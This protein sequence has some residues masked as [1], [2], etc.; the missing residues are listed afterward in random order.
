MFFSRLVIYS[1]NQC[2]WNKKHVFYS[3]V[4][5]SIKYCPVCDSEVDMKIISH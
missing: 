4:I 3:D 1:C 2:H 5:V